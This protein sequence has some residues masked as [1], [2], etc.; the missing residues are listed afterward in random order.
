MRAGVS[1]QISGIRLK[2]GQNITDVQTGNHLLGLVAAGDQAV[3]PLARQHILE[4]RDDP[5]LINYRPRRALK[6]YQAGDAEA[7]DLTLH[8]AQEAKERSFQSSE[9]QSGCNQIDIALWGLATR[10]LKRCQVEK[11][12]S[13]L[14]LM[15]NPAYKARVLAESYAAGASPDGEAAEKAIL[16]C[17]QIYST[18]PHEAWEVLDMLV[19]GGFPRIVEAYRDFFITKNTRVNDIVTS[20]QRLAVL[21][22]A[23]ETAAK[24][25][26]LELAQREDFMKFLPFLGDVGLKRY[27]YDGAAA[28]HRVAPSR[29]LLKEMLAVHFTTE[30]WEHLWDLPLDIPS[31]NPGDTIYFR[32]NDVKELAEHLSD[33]KIHFEPQD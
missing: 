3:I 1:E 10:M 7:L 20:P 6:L 2:T 33:T 19:K 16:L 30:Q 23:G 14:A 18:Q 28:L 15:D 9:D 27:A 11:M 24:D 29:R 25:R 12:D 26:M 17:D 13:L 8:T 5:H 22:K 21:Y 31:F 4:T 32:A